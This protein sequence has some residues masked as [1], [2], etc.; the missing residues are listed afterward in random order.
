M[1]VCVCMC[2]C[3][4]VCVFERVFKQLRPA[5]DCKTPVLIGGKALPC[6]Q[7]WQ[8]CDGVCFFPEFFFSFF[9]FISFIEAFPGLR[10]CGSPIHY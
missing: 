7:S 10:G 9:L 1:W 8:R 6:L 5:S 3:A 2:V 4:R